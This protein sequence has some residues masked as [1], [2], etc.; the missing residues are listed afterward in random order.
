MTADKLQC[1]GGM[2][3]VCA[4]CRRLLREDARVDLDVS[5]PVVQS[6]LVRQILSEPKPKRPKRRVRPVQNRRKPKEIA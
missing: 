6:D 4:S 5:T 2:C 3:G 1:R